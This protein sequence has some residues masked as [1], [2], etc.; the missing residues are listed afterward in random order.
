[1]SIYD[2]HTLWRWRN[3]PRGTAIMSF[4]W[5][6]STDIDRTVYECADILRSALHPA[7][8]WWI[9]LSHCMPISSFVRSLEVRVL[10]KGAVQ[11]YMLSPVDYH[12]T[13][14]TL[15]ANAVPESVQARTVWVPEHGQKLGYTQFPWLTE[16]DVQNGLLAILT[17]PTFATFAETHAANL[18]ADAG[19]LIEPII[20]TANEGAQRIIRGSAMSRV[21]RQLHRRE[22]R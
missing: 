11:N 2:Y 18:V 1:M 17:W 5:R 13:R 9:S 14:I 16:N 20:P 12:G 22:V 19:I 8:E 4:Y 15:F 10:G 21:S 6:V 7:S 3:P